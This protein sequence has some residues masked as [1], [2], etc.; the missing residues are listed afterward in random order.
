M[1]GKR[2]LEIRP[3]GYD[4]GVAAERLAAE[5]PDRTPV[6]IGDDTT[7]EEA[8]RATEGG[9][10]IKV[11]PGPTAAEHRLPDVAAVV[12]YLRRFVA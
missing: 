8:F 2:V 3:K 1:W 4:K 10:T 11:G 9:V 7:D 12:A 5:H 6:V